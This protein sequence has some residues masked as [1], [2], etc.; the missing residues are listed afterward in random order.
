VSKVRGTGWGPLVQ[1]HSQSAAKDNS[2]LLG[3]LPPSIT[4]DLGG[5]AML[6]LA[7]E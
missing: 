6:H 3:T 4:A 7:P 1:R 5:L 2:L